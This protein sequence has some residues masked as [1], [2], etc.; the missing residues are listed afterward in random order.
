MKL[1]TRRQDETEALLGT[2]VNE[3]AQQLQGG[4]I[5]PVQ[6]FHNEE[7]RL[8][9]R[10]RVQPGQNGL[11]RFLALSLWRQGERGIGG[12]QRK[13]QQ[14]RQQRHGLRQCHPRGG[15]RGFQGPHWFGW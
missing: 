13:R 9:L 14:R 8:P 2:L 7:D 4:G 12:G 1:G 6:V 10:F 5:E 3:Q 11:Q 15:Q